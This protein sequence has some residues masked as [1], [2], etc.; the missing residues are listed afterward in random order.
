VLAAH[1]AGSKADERGLD[2]SEVV[3]AEVL[4]GRERGLEI[5]GRLTGRVDRQSERLKK[6]AAGR[7]ADLDDLVLRFGHGMRRRRSTFLSQ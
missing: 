6:S 4:A 5:F 7:F 2:A 1:K 3:I